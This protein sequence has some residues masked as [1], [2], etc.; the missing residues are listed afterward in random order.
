[1]RRMEGE[2][3]DH[4][5]VRKSDDYEI[6]EYE[7]ETEDNRRLPRCLDSASPI[8]PNNDEDLTCS[9]YV[10]RA[11]NC[12]SNQGNELSRTNLEN[13]IR[14]SG[15]LADWQVSETSCGLIA[16]F[17]RETDAEKLLQRGD[18]A[19]VFQGPVQV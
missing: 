18:L 13:A 10:S 1:M 16:A 15:P 5:L 11:N 9:L 14:A 8:I 17:A 19:R 2:P 3:N 4:Q 7:G 12:Q 6:L